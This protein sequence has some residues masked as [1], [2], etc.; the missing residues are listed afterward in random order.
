M[1][2]LCNWFILQVKNIIF[3]TVGVLKE[4]SRKKGQIKVWFGEIEG[5]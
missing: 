5:K 2:Q 3:I 1:K 4:C